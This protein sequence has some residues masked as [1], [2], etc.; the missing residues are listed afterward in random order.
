MPKEDKLFLMIVSP[1]P[2]NRLGKDNLPREEIRH[3]QIDVINR[4]I[5]HGYPLHIRT[6]HFSS[7]YRIF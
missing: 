2:R 4:N 3:I 7:V 5:V 6:Y 1:D